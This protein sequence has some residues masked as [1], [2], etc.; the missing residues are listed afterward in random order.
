MI[1]IY[2]PLPKSPCGRRSRSCLKMLILDEATSHLDTESE[3]II[4]RATDALVK[5]RTSF[6][7][8]HRLSTVIHAD[9]I[10]VF[11]K[12]KIEAMGNHAELLQKSATYARLHSLQFAD[13]D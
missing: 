13:E 1:L 2:A 11:D 6:I 8:A 3:Q 10:L 4:A 5:N 7:I 9:K 12:G